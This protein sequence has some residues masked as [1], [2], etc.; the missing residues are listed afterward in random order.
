MTL[1]A[2]ERRELLAMA[3]AFDAFRE[4]PEMIASWSGI[5]RTWTES[6]A[7]RVE[8]T[9]TSEQLE[10][11]SEERGAVGRTVESAPEQRPPTSSQPLSSVESAPSSSSSDLNLRNKK[12]TARV[13]P[14][15]DDALPDDFRTAYVEVV[16]ERGV[17]LPSADYLWRKFVEHLWDKDIAF[18]TRWNLKRKWRDSWCWYENPIEEAPPAVESESRPV[19]KLVELDPE[20]RARRVERSLAEQRARE[21]VEHAKALPGL[22]AGAAALLE[23]FAPRAPPEPRSASA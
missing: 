17:M 19:T 9:S 13:R 12:K 14:H 7:R 20:E 23:V 3:E 4:S 2:L 11:V 21:K 6:K 10:L 18:T 16:A 5:L 22:R 1:S 15:T 8:A